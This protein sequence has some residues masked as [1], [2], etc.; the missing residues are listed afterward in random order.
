MLRNVKIYKYKE[1]SI[2][3]GVK[4]RKY[5]WIPENVSRFFWLSVSSLK[6]ILMCF[7][8]SVI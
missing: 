2:N 7:K 6:F 3:V 8:K 4:M 1:T 5:K